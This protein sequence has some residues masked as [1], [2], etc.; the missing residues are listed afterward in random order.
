VVWS[1]DWRVDRG[2]PPR[3]MKRPRPQPRPS[4]TRGKYTAYWGI[5]IYRVPAHQA[6]FHAVSSTRSPF[7][8]SYR[9]KLGPGAVA[10]PPPS[11][12]WRSPLI[13]AIVFRSRLKTRR[14]ADDLR[15]RLGPFTILNV[16]YVMRERQHFKQFMDV[17]AG[18]LHAGSGW[19]INR[20]DQ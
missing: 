10:L 8:D 5:N 18:Y 6:C 7:P 9:D 13:R 16:I 20:T 4:S 14:S 1:S 15:P 11:R 12:M 19:C 3:L 17:P 2:T